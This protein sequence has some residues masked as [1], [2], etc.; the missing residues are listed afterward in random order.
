MWDISAETRML[1]EGIAREPM[2]A[3][4]A[5]AKQVKPNIDGATWYGYTGPCPGG[6]NQSYTFFVYA[7]DVATLP[8]V[9]PESTSVAADAAVKAHQLAVAHLT[10]MA[11]K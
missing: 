6:A 10:G 2:P 3:T 5:G 8:G 7:L 1:P 4:P 11:S 9:T